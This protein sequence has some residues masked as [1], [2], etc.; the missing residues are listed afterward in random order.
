MI[1]IGP[2]LVGMSSALLMGLTTR[3]WRWEKLA[4]R[5]RGTDRK[6]RAEPA[7]RSVDSA[8]NPCLARSFSFFSGAS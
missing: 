7:Q 6:L 8:R 2:F 3:P 1:G 5:T 4:E